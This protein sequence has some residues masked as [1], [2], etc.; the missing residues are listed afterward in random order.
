M[1]QT[2]QTFGNSSSADAKQAKLHT[3]IGF[4]MP[5]K[6]DTAICQPHPRLP[7][8]TGQW[9]DGDKFQIVI[10]QN[11]FI[12]GRAPDSNLVVPQSAPYVSSRHIEIQKMPTGYAVV[13]LNSTNGTRLNHR[14]IFAMDAT[15]LDDGDSIQIG[16]VDAELS[17]HFRLP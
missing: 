5:E 13:D 2:N 9:P 6:Y 15:K 4:V 14:P 1:E 8:L 10:A 11:N 12:I 7:H 16:P 17:L 3:V